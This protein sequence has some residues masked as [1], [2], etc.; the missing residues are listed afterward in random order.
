LLIQVEYINA[1]ITQT[2]LN[3]SGAGMILWDS[4]S[5]WLLLL[6]TEHTFIKP[7]SVP[8]T[9]GSWS[10]GRKEKEESETIALAETIRYTW[11]A[12][13]EHGD[14]CPYLLTYLFIYLFIYL[15]SNISVRI[16]Y[17]LLMLPKSI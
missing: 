8:R 6:S 15:A 4:V 17:F 11:E 13:E 14:S 16:H 2:M 1:L 5:P 9:L 10:V 3:Y 12:A 7:C